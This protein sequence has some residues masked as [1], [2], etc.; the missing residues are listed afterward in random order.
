MEAH[1]EGSETKAQTIIEM[2]K[3]K[4]LHMGY[5]VHQLR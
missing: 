4:F 3:S 1:E 5:T 2:F